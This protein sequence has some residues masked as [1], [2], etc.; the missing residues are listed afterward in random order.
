MSKLFK[1]LYDIADIRCRYQRIHEEVFG[2]SAR[3]I[4]KSLQG[5]ASGTSSARSVELDRLLSRL[6]AAQQDLDH[7]GEE[8]LSIRRGGEI[9]SA[10][11]AYARALSQSNASLKAFCEFRQS[12]KGSEED[13]ERLNTLKVAYD[14]A[15]QYQKRL[16]RRLNELISSL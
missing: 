15:V 1:V 16:G 3:R 4:L 11:M 5:A 6:D 12:I 8:D 2:F 14:D 9:Q 7:L 10:L 13:H